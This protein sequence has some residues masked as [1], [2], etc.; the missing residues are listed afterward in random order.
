[1]YSNSTTD[2]STDYTHAYSV[3]TVAVR[4]LTSRIATRRR[5]ASRPFCNFPNPATPATSGRA[6]FTDTAPLPLLPTRPYHLTTSWITDLTA[7]I[8]AKH[9]LQNLSSARQNHPIHPQNLLNPPPFTPKSRLTALLKRT[10]MSGN[11]RNFAKIPTIPHNPD[12]P[13]NPENPDSDDC[14]VIP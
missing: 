8:H 11:E 7:Q 10:E 9:P 13:L 12:N 3:V 4:I 14:E 1:M 5:A 6:H 2:S